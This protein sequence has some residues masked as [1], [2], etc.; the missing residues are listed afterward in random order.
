MLSGIQT[1]KN[2]VK[3]ASVFLHELFKGNSSTFWGTFQNS[4]GWRNHNSL[5]GSV[6][7]L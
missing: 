2:D 5:S 4:K 6:F 3:L 1:P 7:S